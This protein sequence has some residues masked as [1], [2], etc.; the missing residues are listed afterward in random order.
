MNK[1][2]LFWKADNTVA[3]MMGTTLTKEVEESKF[4]HYGSFRID[5]ADFILSLSRMTQVSPEAIAVTW[6]NETT[7]R[8]Y[9]EP[10]KNN[11]PENF[12][13]WDVGPF[14][15][16]VF[17]TKGDLRVKRISGNG[18]TELGMFGHAVD[19]FDGEPLQN[20][21]VAIRRLKKMGKTDEER[22]VTYTGP[23]ARPSRLESWKEFS[24]L[25]QKF[26]EIYK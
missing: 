19:L 13:A 7:F 26:F 14:Q 20:G 6:L 5:N 2:D 8:F 24:P 15:T 3:L 22:V 17:W 25:F 21:L 11:Q 18:L 16:N 23:K 10:N 9:S 1:F 4:G 12:D